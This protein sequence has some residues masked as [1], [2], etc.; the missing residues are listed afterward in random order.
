MDELW[1]LVEAARGSDGASL[2]RAAEAVWRRA[3]YSI[4]FLTED[5]GE[6]IAAMD[7]FCDSVFPLSSMD[8]A[9]VL[10]APWPT[11][12]RTEALL[13]LVDSPYVKPSFVRLDG[14]AERALESG[15]ERLK[16]LVLTSR[17]GTLERPTATRVL[18]S[19]DPATVDVDFLEAVFA[20]DTD[21]A[22][23][24]S[25]RDTYDE[26]IWRLTDHPDPVNW[27][28]C[29]QATPP[30]GL[31]FVR[32]GLDLLGGRLS[33]APGAFE[34]DRYLEKVIAFLR[35][36]ELTEWESTPIPQSH[37]SPKKK[38]RSFSGSELAGTPA[39]VAALARAPEVFPM[40]VDDSEETLSHEDLCDF[41]G[42]STTDD[43][44]WDFGFNDEIKSIVDTGPDILEED[45][46]E[47]G[48]AAH[49]DVVAADHADREWFVLTF[50]REMEAGEVLAICIDT[51]THAHLELARH[52]AT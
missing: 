18:E 51:L 17:L 37:L 40:I 27:E 35:G 16:R 9:D 41:I 13:S 33:A 7:A 20:R 45:L 19:L 29:P 12:R 43:V 44:T 4:I 26:L 47:A 36:A 25:L 2:P 6:V 42:V 14:L 50:A 5:T 8:P 3:H 30:R 11:P 31:R 15:D 49:P 32:R 22:C 28:Y 23:P 39:V 52:M 48:F 21:L 10:D 38:S 1:R 34:E 46:L 24:P